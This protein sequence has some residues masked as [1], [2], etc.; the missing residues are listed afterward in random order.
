MQCALSQIAIPNLLFRK[1]A[2]RIAGVFSVRRLASDEQPRCI[3]QILLAFRSMFDPFWIQNPFFDVQ[4]V[5]SAYTPSADLAVHCAPLRWDKRARASC[6][7]AVYHGLY[8]A[9][10]GFFL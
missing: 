2:T 3:C 5:N 8:G 10:W 1:E 7:R 9:F 6:E 4:I